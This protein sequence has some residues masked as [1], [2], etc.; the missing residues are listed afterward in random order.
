MRYMMLIANQEDAWA[1]MSADEQRELYQRI[2]EWFAE[3]DKAGTIIE[4][5]ELQGV[6]TATTVRRAAGGRVAITD[7][8]FVEAKEQLGGYAILEVADLD[9]AIAIASSW[10]HA[11]TME[12]RPVIDRSGMQP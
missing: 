4:G 6:E 7:G 2:A 1:A 11:V 12:I 3:H 5:Y 10:P 8:P 9:A